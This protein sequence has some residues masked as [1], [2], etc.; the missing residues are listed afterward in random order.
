[1]KKNSGVTLIELV[2]FIVIMGIISSTVGPMFFAILKNAPKVQHYSA[3][4]QLASQCLEGYLG[5]RYI[6]GYSTVLSATTPALCTV[7]TG[8]TITKS[9]TNTTKYSEASYKTI[10]VTV[11]GEG[12]ATMSLLV[13]D[14]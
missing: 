7:P 9:V 3:A 10:T 11:A 4:T 2:M 14:Y 8:Y 1:M 5:E 6:K 13:A 12:N